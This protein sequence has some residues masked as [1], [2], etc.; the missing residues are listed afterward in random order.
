MIN[1]GLESVRKEEF[2]A[3]LNHEIYFGTLGDVSAEIMNTTSR[4]QVRNFNGYTCIET[5]SI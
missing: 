1:F 4:I 3:E 2:A 5:S